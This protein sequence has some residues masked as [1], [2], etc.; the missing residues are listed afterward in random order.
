MSSFLQIQ[1]L[2]QYT[3]QRVGPTLLGCPLSFQISQVCYTQSRHLGCAW[4]V[5]LVGSLPCPNIVHLLPDKSSQHEN[6]ININM[7]S[8]PRGALSQARVWCSLPQ[9]YKKEQ[10]LHFWK[11]APLFKLQPQDF[12]SL[13]PMADAGLVIQVDS[14]S[15]LWDLPPPTRWAGHR[16]EQTAPPLLWQGGRR[17]ESLMVLVGP[18]TWE[19][20]GEEGLPFSPFQFR[21]RVLNGSESRPQPSVAAPDQK[22]KARSK[23]L[24]GVE[25]EP[26]CENAQV[27]TEGE[28]QGTLRD[29]R[30]CGSCRRSDLLPHPLHLHSLHTRLQKQSMFLR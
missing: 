19:G 27:S 11:N 4:I 2:Y 13:S 6:G 15:P 17:T 23:V 26:L 16:G 10:V 8:L 30:G 20:G 24:G 28:R 9:T 7:T 3:W 5:T 12:L 14:I 18:T 25:L 21:L 1:S 22:C 29:E